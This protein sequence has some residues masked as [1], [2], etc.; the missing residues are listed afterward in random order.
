MPIQK[1]ENYQD[2]LMIDHFDTTVKMSTYLVAFI[3]CDYSRSTNTTKN[4]ITVRILF[5]F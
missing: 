3:V 2:D 4:N 1:T 5:I